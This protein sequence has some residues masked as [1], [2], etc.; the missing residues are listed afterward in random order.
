M[1]EVT[2]QMV[3]ST[4]QTAGI[5]VGIFYYIMTL[6]NQQ[7]SQQLAVE[8]RNAQFFMQL[9]TATTDEKGINLAFT[10]K[11]WETFDEWWEQYGIVNNPEAFGHWFKMMYTYEMYGVMVKRGLLDITLVDDLFSGGVLM[12]WNKYKSVIYGMRKLFGYPQL[13][14]HQEYLANEIQKIV[15]KQHTNF[16][17][18]L[19]P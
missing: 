14:E 5:L 4:L 12:M 18:K 3:L 6:R 11:T 19:N 13:Q 17:G 10:E 2:Y 1:V 15:D 9:F 8:T 16:V 7:R